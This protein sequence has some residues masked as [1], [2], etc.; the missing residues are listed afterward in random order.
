M[1]NFDFRAFARTTNTKPTERDLMHLVMFMRE[2][3]RREILTFSEVEDNNGALYD[4]LKEE[5]NIS[6]FTVTVYGPGTDSVVG[7]YGVWSSPENPSCGNIWMHTT[8]LLDSAQKFNFLRMGHHGVEELRLKYN[9]LD[10]WADS[11]NKLH[12]DWLRWQGF[13]NR[14][15]AEVNGVRFDHFVIGGIQPPDNWLMWREREKRRKMN[16]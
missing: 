1:S 7:I 9:L 15:N 8:T 10:C 11:R 16:V 3:D 12:C 14:A 2:E 13:A 6:D 5:V 4:H